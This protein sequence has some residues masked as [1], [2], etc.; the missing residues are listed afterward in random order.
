MLQRPVAHSLVKHP[1]LRQQIQS[2]V[3]LYESVVRM[4][5]LRARR[6]LRNAMN[7]ALA[8]VKFEREGRGELRRQMTQGRK[9]PVKIDRVRQALVMNKSRSLFDELRVQSKHDTA[10]MKR[11]PTVQ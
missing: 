10:Q 9:S 3:S 11:F 6:R 5:S 1:W 7:V 2:D 8:G 4:Q